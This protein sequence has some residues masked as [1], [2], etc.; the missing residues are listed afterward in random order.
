MTCGR[1][2]IVQAPGPGTRAAALTI[3]L[4]PQTARTRQEHD[5][6]IRHWPGLGGL[7]RV[8][9]YRV[10]RNLSIA[11][12]EPIYTESSHEDGLVKFQAIARRAD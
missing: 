12:G 9:P 4:A 10:G 2:K 1:W 6:P 3:R 8:G 5:D 7:V 11:T